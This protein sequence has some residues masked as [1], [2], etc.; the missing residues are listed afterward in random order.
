MRRTTTTMTL[1]FG[2]AYVSC[3]TSR[4]YSIFHPVS[5]SSVESFLNAS[6]ACYYHQHHRHTQRTSHFDHLPC[7]LQTRDFVQV[8]MASLVENTLPTPFLSL[9]I[10]HMNDGL[11]TYVN[12]IKELI[13]IFFCRTR[14]CWALSVVYREPLGGHNYAHSQN[15]RVDEIAYPHCSSS[16][17]LLQY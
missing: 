16:V 8:T 10:G 15:M 11:R 3:T 1:L 6:T 4:L 2:Y 9:Y 14:S 5:R 12:D 7:S 13:G 17:T